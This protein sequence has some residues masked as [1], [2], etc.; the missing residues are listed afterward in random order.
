MKKNGKSGNR[1]AGV[2][3]GAGCALISLGFFYVLG[4]AST[5]QVRIDTEPRGAAVAVDGKQIGRAPVMTPVSNF[6]GGH[7]ATVTADDGS[8]QTFALTKG[9]KGVNI[10]LGLLLNPF[11]LLWCYGP[12]ENQFFTLGGASG[13]AGAGSRPAAR[14]SN[15]ANSSLDGALSKIVDALIAD[16]SK[17]STIA[18]LSVS[19]RDRETG[20]YIMD[21]LEYQLVDARQFKMVDR[22]TVDAIRQEQDFQT[23]GDVDDKSAVSIGKML[24]AGI[25]ITGTLTTRGNAQRLSLKALDVKTAQIITMVRE[26]F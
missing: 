16:L 14:Q 17:N 25:V 2:V 13:G 21:E 11:A 12:E 5:S 23:S 7:E 18:V 19:T 3:G 26:E 10:A 8:S 6:I 4:C 24:G 9:V 15:P 20:A 22:K 1:F